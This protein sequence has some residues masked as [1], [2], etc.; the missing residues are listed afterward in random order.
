MIYEKVQSVGIYG[1][2]SKEEGALFGMAK[3]QAGGQG[4]GLSYEPKISKRWLL[5]CAPE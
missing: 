4:I 5:I 3:L 2:A 1:Q